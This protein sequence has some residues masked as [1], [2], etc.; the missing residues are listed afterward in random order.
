[1]LYKDKNSNWSLGKYAAVALLVGFISL[2]VASCERDS[3][4][5][6]KESGK[7]YEYGNVD[8]QGTVKGSDGKP[9]PGASIS[10]KGETRGTT[11]DLEGRFRMNVPAGSRL[12]VKYESLHS[13]DLAISPTYKSTIF[14]ITLNPNSAR[15]EETLNPAS[16]AAAPSA[17]GK[18]M[19]VTVQPKSID[20]EP[21]F[22]VVQ[23]QPQFPGGNKAMYK[24]LGDNIKYPEPAT[25]AN[26]SGKV[27]LNFVVTK[28]GEI[29]NVTILKEMGFG[30]DE[31]AMRVVSLMPRW[32]PG[33][34]DGKPLNVRYNLPIAFELDKKPELKTGK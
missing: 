23:E 3:L 22:T 11:T 32:T 26:V 33:K 10:V 30:I 15:L 5:S 21:I 1:M 16:L 29:K 19:H 28:E 17:D 18:S 13:I 6:S 8:V 27:F 2:V 31:E 7:K 9:L 12:V 14:S 24:F 34:Q 25:R 20:G 4:P